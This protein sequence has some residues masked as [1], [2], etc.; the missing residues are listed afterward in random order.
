MDII[1]NL[2]ELRTK[3]E[4]VETLKEAE[5]IAEKLFHV[6]NEHKNI[7]AISA[8]QVGI[9]KS[10]F[11]VNLIKPIWFMNPR[12]THIESPVTIEEKCS[13]MSGVSIPHVTRFKLVKIKTDNYEDEI[14]LDIR[15]IPDF[16]L[17]R[18]LESLES[19]AIQHQ[20]DHLEGILISDKVNRNVSTFKALKRNK[21]QGKENGNALVRI[22]NAQ[23]NKIQSVKR[24]KLQRF[25]NKGWLLL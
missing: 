11:V 17:K 21:K 20:I 8:N 25:L 24:K 18:C 19:I 10:V 1:Q 12:I 2:T 7:F 22:I 3:T 4:K 6:L 15:N 16:Q 5:S 14:T 23:N 9:N 13:S